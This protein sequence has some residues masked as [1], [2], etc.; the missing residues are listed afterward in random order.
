MK[1]AL[2]AF[3]VAAPTYAATLDPIAWIPAHGF[4]P[5]SDCTE[6]F[7]GPGWY[8]AHYESAR[9]KGKWVCKD[10]PYLGKGS[11]FFLDPETGV[12]DAMWMD[13]ETGVM[14]AIWMSGPASVSQ[15]A[16]V[17]ATTRV[18]PR[19]LTSFRPLPALNPCCRPGARIPIPALPDTP[20]P[21]PIPLPSALLALLTGLFGFGV[22]R[23]VMRKVVELANALVEGDREWNPKHPRSRW[24]LLAGR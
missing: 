12:M 4:R 5:I 16:I 10:E 3:F 21:I 18:V 2:F 8:E 6:Q 19:P 22:I 23:A 15:S 1:M 7:S 17:L 20:S 13:P 24:I 9:S 11:A 14:D